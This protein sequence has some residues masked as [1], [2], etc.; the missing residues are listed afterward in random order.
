MRQEAG[1]RADGHARSGDARALAP[2]WVAVTRRNSV[3]LGCPLRRNYAIQAAA[4][5]SVFVRTSCKNTPRT[6]RGCVCCDKPLAWRT[7]YSVTAGNGAWRSL[8]AHLLWEQRVG[9][10]NPS[11]PTTQLKFCMTGSSVRITRHVEDSNPRPTDESG[12]T[13]WRS[14]D[15]SIARRATPQ[16]RGASAPSV[17]IDV[18]DDQGE[19]WDSGAKLVSC[20][21]ARAWARS[22]K[23]PGH[24]KHRKLAI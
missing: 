6:A 3:P 20:S 11:A 2:G 24:A 5:S 1:C 8:V 23:P 14:S 17:L 21:V 22:E 13:T 19:Y 10:S 18:E 16:G 9:G 12:S 15:K 7:R 4:P